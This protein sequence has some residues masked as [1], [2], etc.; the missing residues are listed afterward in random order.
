MKA[1]YVLGILLILLMATTACVYAA[2]AT[3]GNHKFAIPDGYSIYEQGDDYV[4]IANNDQRLIRVGVIDEVPSED[5]L[6]SRYEAANITVVDHDTINENGSE[7]VYVHF[8]DKQSSVYAY[9]WNADDD[10]LMVIYAYGEGEPDT[11]WADSPV[12][13]IHDSMVKI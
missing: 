6:I 13:E 4:T 7:V 9:G 11:D 12:K 5:L 2:D 3:L 10:A 1:K 8:I